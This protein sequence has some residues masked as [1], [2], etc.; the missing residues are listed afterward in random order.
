[1]S[2]RQKITSVVKDVEKK[3]PYTF[4]GGKIA[5]DFI[6]QDLEVFLETELPYDSVISFLNMYAKKMK[7]VCWIF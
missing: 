2:K 3:A 7:S 4:W 1:M 6:E 5:I